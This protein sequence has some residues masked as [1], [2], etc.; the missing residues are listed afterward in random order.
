MVPG[1]IRLSGGRGRGKNKSIEALFLI[2]I[3]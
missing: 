3:G 2:E 1:E